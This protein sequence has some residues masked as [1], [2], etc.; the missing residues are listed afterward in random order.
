[1]LT[2]PSATPIEGRLQAPL[3]AH[4]KLPKVPKLL[5]QQRFAA[6]VHAVSRLTSSLGLFLLFAPACGES[7]GSSDDATDATSAAEETTS[8]EGTDSE[9]TGVE[10]PDFE[11]DVQPLFE[12]SCL[13]HFMPS[14]GDEMT[15]PYLTLNAGT[16]I[17]E[18]VDVDSTQ[19]PSMKRVAPGDVDN[20]YLVHKLRGT[21]IDVGGPSDSNRMPPLAPLAE[22]DIM[23][24]E[25]WITAGANP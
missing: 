24:I 23:T 22:A 8:D 19:L 17:G 12:A 1:V 3:I 10:V 21:H 13:C 6:M 7:G 16:G 4:R 5:A 9:T 2:L 15:A 18:L 20:S 14:N 25:A 11:M